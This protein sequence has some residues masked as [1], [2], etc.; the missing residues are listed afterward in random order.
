MN[1]FYGEKFQRPQNEF[2]NAFL[3]IQ[4]HNESLPNRSM[5]SSHAFD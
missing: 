3:I 1:D 2:G 4:L 5:K